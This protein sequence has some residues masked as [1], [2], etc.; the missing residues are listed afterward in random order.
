MIREPPDH[1]GSEPTPD[2]PIEGP[3]QDIKNGKYIPFVR[4]C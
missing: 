3:G 4:T 2:I 1:T